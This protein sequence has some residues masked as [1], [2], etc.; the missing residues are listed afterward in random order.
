[1]PGGA[2]AIRQPWR[3]AASYLAAAGAGARRPGRHDRATSSR[4]AAVLAMARRGINAPATSSAGRL[5][6]A[7]AAL[8]GVR[9]IDQL[10]GPGG[11]R[12]GAA[13]RPGRDRTATRCRVGRRDA[14]ADPRSPTWSG[15]PRT[16]WP[17]GSA[18]P[19]IAA[20][21]HNGVAAAIGA[22]CAGCGT[23]R[24]GHGRAVRRRV[25][26]PAADRAGGRAARRPRVP[27]AGASPGAVQRRRAS[28]W[29]R[30]WSRRPGVRSA[31]A[32][33]DRAR[34]G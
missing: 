4:W 33:R 13:R 22:V 17:P 28:A 18:R 11:D 5:F 24:P 34:S 14:V 8:L 23:H 7:V 6:D 9:D 26:E 20:R 32:R 10:R 29:V 12:A 25:P 31:D 2:A 3:M 21:F 19:V 16:T 27:G 30:P 1:M 15:P